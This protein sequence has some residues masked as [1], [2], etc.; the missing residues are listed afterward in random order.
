M[1]VERRQRELLQGPR[2]LHGRE[3]SS[4][5]FRILDHEAFQSSD[6]FKSGDWQ[7]IRRCAAEWRGNRV[8]NQR[9]GSPARSSIA[10]SAINGRPMSEVGSSVWIR[11][12]SAMP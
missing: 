10:V 5:R 4:R 8:E 3:E 1:L 11:S 2:H 6:L 12:M 7:G 9:T